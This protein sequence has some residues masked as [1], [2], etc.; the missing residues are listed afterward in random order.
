MWYN[1]LNK[2]KT[3]E[4]PNFKFLDYVDDAQ[5]LESTLAILNGTT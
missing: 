1:D 5:Y 3:K 2:L 4:E